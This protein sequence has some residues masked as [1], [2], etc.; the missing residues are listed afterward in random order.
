M[1]SGVRGAC[2][3]RTAMRDGHDQAIFAQHSYGLARRIPGDTEQADEILLRRQRIEVRPELTCLNPGPKP[4]GNLT[5]GGHRR[6]RVNLWHLHAEKLADQL[7]LSSFIYV[8]RRR[9]LYR[10]SL[11]RTEGCQECLPTIMRRWLARLTG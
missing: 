9:L 5:V 8:Y 4:L 6:T 7:Q 3:I 2:D 11:P 10:T 1:T